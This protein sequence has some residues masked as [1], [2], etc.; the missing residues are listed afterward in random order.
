MKKRKKK[1]VKGVKRGKKGKKGEKRKRIGQELKQNLILKGEK[2]GGEDYD[3]VGNYISLPEPPVFR[4]SRTQQ[5]QN[6]HP[7]IQTLSLFIFSS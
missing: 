7:K 4:R 2:G 5:R 1:G 6:Y 3:F